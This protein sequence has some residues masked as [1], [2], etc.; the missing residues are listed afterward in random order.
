MTLSAN[1]TEAAH[2]TFTVDGDAIAE[3]FD[4]TELTHDYTPTQEGT[5]TVLFTADNGRRRPRLKWTCWC[6]P[7]A[8]MWRPRPLGRRMA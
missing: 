6:F 4:A 1:A 5:T 8:P 3:A 2:L 7:T